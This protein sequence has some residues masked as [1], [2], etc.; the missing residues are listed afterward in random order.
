MRLG[1][2][3]DQ[4]AEEAAFANAGVAAQHDQPVDLVLQAQVS[5]L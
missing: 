3:G 1:E 4:M 2:A 5:M